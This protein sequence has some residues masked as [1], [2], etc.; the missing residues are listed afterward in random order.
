ME[1]LKLEDLV[2]EDDGGEVFDAFA[3]KNTQ[4]GKEDIE[5][6]KPEQPTNNENNT[7][8]SEDEAASPNNPESGSAEENGN[9]GQ[10]GEANNDGEGGNSSSPKL[11]DSEQLYSTLATHLINKGALSDLDPLTIKSVDDLNAAIEKEAASR[12]NSRQ[13]AIDEALKVGAPA[14]PV[15]EMSEVI[16]KLERITPEF[17]NEPAN[18]KLRKNLISQDFVNKGYDQ[19][20]AD[21]L[22]QR[23]VDSGTDKEDAE[24]AL[25]GIIQTEKNNREALIRKF[26]DDERESINKLKNALEDDKGTV[27]S[28]KLSTEQQ[29]EIFKQMTTGVDGRDTAFIKYQKENPIESRVKLETIFYLTKGLTDF[30]IFGETA[31]TETAKDLENLL[32]GTSFTEEGKVKTEIKDENSNFALK[33]FKDLEIDI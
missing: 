11:N 5:I 12:L 15:A 22:A 10:A 4:P 24:F 29:M 33:D 18:V 14:A 27:A 20:R 30:S 16:D 2:F 31:K 9:Q 26:A 6:P 1:E 17:L 23:S 19:A 28:I 21:T 8:G 7:P 25:K 3:Q 13:K 32:R